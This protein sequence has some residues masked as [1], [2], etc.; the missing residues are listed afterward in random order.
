M[1]LVFKYENTDEAPK[2]VSPYNLGK[3]A[4]FYDVSLDYLMG[5]TEQRKPDH[6]PI[7]DLHLSSEALEVLKKAGSTTAC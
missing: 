3:L 6:T 4:R 7:E 5:M 2:D 1:T